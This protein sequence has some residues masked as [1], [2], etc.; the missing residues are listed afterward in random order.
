MN[1]SLNEQTS[2]KKKGKKN[3]SEEKKICKIIALHWYKIKEYPKKSLPS[4]H[5]LLQSD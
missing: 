4:S 3:R 2:G 1:K 5:L